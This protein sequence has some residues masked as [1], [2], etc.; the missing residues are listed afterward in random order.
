LALKSL[1]CLQER[2]SDSPKLAPAKARFFRH[3]VALS[4]EQ[5]TAAVKDERLQK[6]AC[7]EIA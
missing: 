4:E 5:R 3:W 2:H 1:V 7:E 6:L